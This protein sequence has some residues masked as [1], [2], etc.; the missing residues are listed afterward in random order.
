MPFFPGPTPCRAP[1]SILA[2]SEV[3][4]GI[5]LVELL[6]SETVDNRMTPSLLRAYQSALQH[7]LEASRGFPR[8]GALI[9]SGCLD[10]ASRSS[11]YFSNGLDYALAVRMGPAFGELYNSVIGLLLEFPVP[12]IAALGGH[13]FAGACVLALAHDVRIMNAARGWLC[14]NEALFGAPIGR[15]SAAVLQAK[16]PI[17]TVA[18]VVLRARRYTGAEALDAGLV[19]EAAAPLPADVLDAAVTHARALRSVSQSNQVWGKN[20]ALL[21]RPALQA[22]AEPVTGFAPLDPAVAAR[23]SKL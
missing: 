19:D 15:V 21:V 3:D 16:L 10:P 6:G 20:R 13:V 18:Q 23:V 12:T 9:T 4:D 1:D 22:I 8:G 2:L 14:M 17:R 11:R 5:W 7:V